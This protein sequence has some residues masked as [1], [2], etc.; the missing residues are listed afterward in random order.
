MSR[1]RSGRC[2]SRPSPSGS[3]YLRCQPCRTPQSRPCRAGRAAGAH[4]ALAHAGYAAFADARGSTLARAAARTARPARAAIA[5][6]VG[7]DVAVAVHGV[8]VGVAA[9]AL[10]AVR[11]H[12]ILAAVVV[13]GAFVAAFAVD[14]A[15]LVAAAIRIAGAL[16]FIGKLTDAPVGPEHAA[17]RQRTIAVGLTG[18]VA[19]LERADERVIALRVERTAFA[20]FGQL[21]FFV[22]AAPAGPDAQASK[23]SEDDRVTDSKAHGRALQV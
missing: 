10:A 15:H 6:A 17:L 20:Q 7:H 9:R 18:L 23:G 4:A 21:E 8:A 19:A 12:L 3:P 5:V 13:A 2:R 16:R 22:L 11:A 1:S 14:A